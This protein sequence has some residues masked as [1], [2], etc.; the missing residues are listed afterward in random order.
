MKHRG[1]PTGRG[2]RPNHYY[3]LLGA[4]NVANSEE[5][6]IFPVIANAASSFTLE[7]G[8]ETWILFR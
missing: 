4:A 1:Q 6:R 8:G 5:G 7:T 2:S 3:A